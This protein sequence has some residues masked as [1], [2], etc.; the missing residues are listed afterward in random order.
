MLG[1]VFTRPSD[2]AV[3]HLLSLYPSEMLSLWLDGAQMQTYLETLRKHK[4]EVAAQQY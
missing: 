1:Y 2:N 4:S 3:Q